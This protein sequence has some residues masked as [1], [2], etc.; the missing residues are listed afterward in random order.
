MLYTGHGDA[1][2]TTVVGG[3]PLSK[4]HIRLEAIGALDEAQ[5]QLGIVRAFLNG[6]PLSTQVRRVQFEL[7]LLMADLA[8]VTKSRSLPQHITSNHLMHLEEDITAW[9]TATGG[10]AGFTTPGDS[11]VEAYLHLARTVIR[12]AERQIVALA[13]EDTTIDALILTYTNRLSSW[14]FALTLLVTNSAT[15]FAA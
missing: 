7:S 10:F 3:P 15:S 6:S 9:E 1:G 12:R 4:C 2:Y 14:V 11:L 13:S 5:A 8:T